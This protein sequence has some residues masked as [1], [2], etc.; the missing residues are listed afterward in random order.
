[1]NP[2][3]DH[4]PRTPNPEPEKSSHND[5]PI[6]RVRSLSGRDDRWIGADTES[7]AAA[8][9]DAVGERG[10][11]RQRLARVS[12][13]AD[14]AAGM[15]EPQ[16]PV[17]LRDHR[18][19]GDAGGGRLSTA[20]SSCRSAV[21]S[22]LSGARTRSRRINTC[23]IAARSRRPTGSTGGRVLLHFGAV[24][25]EATRLGQRQAGRQAPRRLR[26][27]H[28]RHHRCASRQ[29]RPGDRRSRLGSDRHGPAAARQAGPQARAAS[30]TPPPPA[31]GRPCGSSRCRAGAST[32]LRLDAGRRC[33]RMCAS[34]CTCGRRRRVGATA[35]AVALDGTARSPVRDGPAGR[36]DR[37]A[38]SRNA[39]L[40]SPDDAV[41]LRPDGHAHARRHVVDA[42]ES[43]FGMRKIV[44]GP[45]RPTASTRLLL[46]GKPLF[47]FGP[48]DQ[49]FWPDGLYTAP[50]DEA[51]RYDIEIDARSSAST[52][53]ASTSRSSRTAGTTGA[54]S[55]ACSSGRTCPAASNNTP[56]ERRA[57]SA[58]ELERMIDAL[59]TT[60]RPSSC[61]CRSTKAGASTTPT[62]IR[63]VDQA[64]SIR[65]AS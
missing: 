65:R 13:S 32:S 17:G 42:V 14:G 57:T 19:R 21:E 63:G 18:T 10:S 16:R 31:S 48:L 47:Q 40:W 20:R 8:A 27:V 41:P 11:S 46:N 39:K 24:D 3:P 38:A 44:A 6:R 26:S 23:G 29:R 34:P 2:E 54:T 15:A 58:D 37:A 45:G 7:A 61:G 1:M 30:G 36:D 12:A 28:L 53:P 4:E 55:S 9:G 50:T 22:V 43:Y 33:R 64:R 25:W 35:R 62:R 52:W 51:L 56:D 60:I 49:G 59:S 5:N